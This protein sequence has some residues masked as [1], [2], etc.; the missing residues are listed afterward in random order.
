MLLVTAARGKAE[1]GKDVFLSE[2]ERSELRLRFSHDFGATIDALR[3]GQ[4]EPWVGR[5]RLR[6]PRRTYRDER[7]GRRPDL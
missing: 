7:R 6:S 3:C 5:D 2:C 1:P 4:R